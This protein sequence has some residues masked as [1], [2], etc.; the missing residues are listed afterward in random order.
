[1]RLAA[2]SQGYKVW[3]KFGT[4]PVWPF[5]WPALQVRQGRQGSESRC[6]LTGLHQASHCLT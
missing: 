1:M 3:L 6:T 4:P 2:V 5:N